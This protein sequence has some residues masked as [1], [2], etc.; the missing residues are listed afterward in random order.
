MDWSKTKTIF[1]VVF[2]ILNI[3]LYL[4]YLNAHKEAQKLEIL[5]ES[6]AIEARLKE[7]NIT[8]IALPTKVETASFL[9]G[10]LKTFEPSEVPYFANQ[11][12]TIESGTKL[13][14]KMEKPTKLRDV[15]DKASYQEFIEMYVHEGASYKLW[16]VDE[17]NRE[18]LFFQKINDRTFYYNVGGA[19]KI[20]WNENGE[21]TNYEQTML[22][23][24]EELEQLE[25]ILPPI[26]IIQVLYTRNFLKPDSQITGM[27]LGYSTLVQFTEAQVFTPTWEVRVKTDEGEEVF[28][29]NADEGKIIEL[30]KGLEQIEEV[31]DE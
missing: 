13:Y 5:G 26:Q 29:L 27:K 17:Q 7:D 23:K 21:V 20:Y 28:F 2:L 11:E 16:E 15:K 8:Y 1:I 10:R 3:F 19:I 12:A 9:S 22:E 4:Q 25:S 24:L 14:V 31:V 6:Q 18:A 30:N